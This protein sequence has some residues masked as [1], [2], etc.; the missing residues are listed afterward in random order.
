MVSPLV[1]RMRLG[2]VLHEL[3]LEAKMTHEQLA[4]KARVPRTDLSR[5]ETGARRTDLD[6]VLKLLDALG[7]TEDSERYRTVVRLAREAL[8]KGWWDEPRFAGMSARQKRCA[9]VESAAV[10]IRHYHTCAMPWMLQTSE[11]VAARDAVWLSDG[12]DLDPIQAVARMRR[13]EEVLRYGGPQITVL[14]EEQVIRRPLVD[15]A[16]MATQLRHLVEVASS[17]EHISIH[18][19]PV[20]ATVGRHSVPLMPFD[21]HNYHDPGDGTAMMVATVNDDL[22]IYDQEEIAPYVRLWDRLYD[23]AMSAEDTAEYIEEHA[24]RA[25]GTVEGPAYV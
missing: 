16:V 1:R 17:M 19:L 24:A 14:L 4:A 13:Q 9:D 22:L 23:A 25:G 20:D 5:L 7:V 18:V 21:L 11:F 15:A 12:A 8:E 3:R 10:T 6:K 2:V